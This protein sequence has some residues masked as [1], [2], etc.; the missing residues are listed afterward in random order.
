MTITIPLVNFDIG[1]CQNSLG[2][3]YIMFGHPVVTNVKVNKWYGYGHLEEI[4]VR[5]A[6]QQLYKFME[7]DFL[8]LHLNNIE[9]MLLLVVQNKLFNL[10][11]DVIADL[12]VELRL[13]YILMQRNKVA[14]YSTRQRK[15]RQK[16][17]TMR[18]LELG[19]II[20]ALTT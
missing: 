20:I 19:T 3:V 17:Y 11:G 18:D 16:K 12:V 13:D 6:D 14:S 5:R 4:D 2:G 8:R 10:N 1:H 9:D 7:G 15:E